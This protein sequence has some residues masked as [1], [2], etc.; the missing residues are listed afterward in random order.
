MKYLCLII[1]FFANYL[2][3]QQKFEVYV[4][5][6]NYYIVDLETETRVETVNYKDAHGAY[7]DILC[8]IGDGFLDL[9]HKEE[10]FVKRFNQRRPESVRINE[11]IF[12]YFYDEVS[13]YLIPGIYS[14]KIV[15]PKR[16][17][18]LRNEKEYLICKKDDNYDVFI[19]TNLNEPVLE[20]VQATNYFF[21][22]VVDKKDNKKLSLHLFYGKDKTYLYDSDFKLVRTETSASD[23]FEVE[24]IVLENYTII[25]D[26]PKVRDEVFVKEV[27]FEKKSKS[28]KINKQVSFMIGSNDIFDWTFY[29]SDNTLFLYNYDRSE[30]YI[31]KVDFENKRFL[32]PTELREKIGL[33][34][35]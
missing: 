3:A 6:D 4:V 35:E 15:L 23:F 29:D 18:H 17:I 20:D 14:E 24:K 26:V 21:R 22:E 7:L 12:F 33:R 9:Y 1:F 19:S 27:L 5:N 13:T 30:Y 2:Y 28:M 31:F 25:E 32:I 11:R 10:G 8:M 16:Y 34:F